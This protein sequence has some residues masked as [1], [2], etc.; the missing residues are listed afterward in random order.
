MAFL[1]RGSKTSEQVMKG[2]DLRV[3]NDSELEMSSSF[4]D[5]SV[6]TVDRNAFD[7]RTV[8]AVQH[9]PAHH[10]RQL[11]AS[12]RHVGHNCSHHWRVV[13]NWP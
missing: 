11:T 10:R 4:D 2:K 9:A 3:R 12:Y 5:R 8:S 6:E 1:N 13:R 7:L